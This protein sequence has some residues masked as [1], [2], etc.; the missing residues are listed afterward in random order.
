MST[1]W[2]QRRRRCKGYYRLRQGVQPLSPRRLAILLC[3]A[4]CQ[5]KGEVPTLSLMA[6]EADCEEEHA[7]EL[8][9]ELVECAGLVEFDE[10]AAAFGLTPRGHAKIEGAA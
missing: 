3:L 5:A 8:L 4:R 7:A 9:E 10:A 6:R 1:R 2:E